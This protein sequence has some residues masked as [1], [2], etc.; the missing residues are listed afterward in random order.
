MMKEEISDDDVRRVRRG[1]IFEYILRDLIFPPAKA[2]NR[3]SRLRGHNVLLVDKDSGDARPMARKAMAKSNHQA[4]V[5][6]TKL[7]DPPRRTNC[8]TAHAP[9][10]DAR[11]QHHGVQEPK[12]AARPHGGRIFGRQNIEQLGF[13]AAEE[14]HRSLCPSL[15][16]YGQ[17]ETT[18]FRR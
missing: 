17:C 18:S 6:R 4:T 7:D 15:T 5:T 2:C 3:L 16:R 13:K 1:E 11:V 14:G 8:M 10:H 12:V 9:S